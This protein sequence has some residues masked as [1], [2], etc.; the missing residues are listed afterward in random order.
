MTTVPSLTCHAGPRV[1]ACG[2]HIMHNLMT[3]SDLSEG[4]SC[5]TTCD[6]MTFRDL[7]GTRA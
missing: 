4:R 3:F 7:S 1:K 6:R 2:R 5:Q